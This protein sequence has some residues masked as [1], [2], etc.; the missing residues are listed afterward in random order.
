M[1]R[2]TTA[3]ARQ[4]RDDEAVGLERRSEGRHPMPGAEEILLPAPALGQ[5]QHPLVRGANELSGEGDD[6]SPKR[7][8]PLEHRPAER[9]PLVEHEEIE[10]QDFQLQVGSVG[11]KLAR[12][13]AVDAEVLLE[14]VDGLLH[15]GPLVVESGRRPPV[16]SPGPSVRR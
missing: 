5:L 2:D 11:K 10:G 7:L 3:L 15:I 9:L 13:D 6:P 12:R 1:Q 8:G 4:R 16:S 14:L